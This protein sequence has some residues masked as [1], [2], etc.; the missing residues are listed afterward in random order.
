MDINVGQ[1]LTGYIQTSSVSSGVENLI[2]RLTAEHSSL[3]LTSVTLF[4]VIFAV[5]DPQAINSGV[6]EIN[7]V[8]LTGLYCA[9]GSDPTL[10]SLL[11]NPH[12]LKRNRRL[13]FL[14]IFWCGCVMGGAIAT[15]SDMWISLV[16]AL[17]CKVVALGMMMFSSAFEV[18]EDWATRNARR[19][20]EKEEEE[21]DKDLAWA[22]E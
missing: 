10:F 19:E 12:V 11:S 4:A 18:P 16:L 3:H 17:E 5:A 14:V 9:L 6:S 13:W 22:A 7:T 8:G 20:K 2:S 1:K 21:K 15:F